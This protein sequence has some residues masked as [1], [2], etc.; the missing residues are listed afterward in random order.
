MQQ[1]KQQPSR[2]QRMKPTNRR[3]SHL[4][5]LLKF[6]RPTN[7]DLLAMTTSRRSTICG[8]GRLGSVDALSGDDVMELS[9]SDGV[10]AIA[11]DAHKKHKSLAHIFTNNNERRSKTTRDP[12]LS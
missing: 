9:P 6:R 12:A 2:L 4:R 1:V 11:K 10:F 5:D 7:H 3:T 8:D